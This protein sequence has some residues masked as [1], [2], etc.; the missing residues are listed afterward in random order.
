M[1]KLDLEIQK[2]KYDKHEEN[3]LI[4]IEEVK[5]L[6]NQ[7]KSKNKTNLKKSYSTSYILTQGNKLLNSERMRY[8]FSENQ[9]MSFMLNII[10]RE[11]KREEL[12]KKLK[13][14]E[15]MAYQRE[16]EIK[17]MREMEKLERDE[18][19]RNLA[20]KM[21]Q[22]EKNIK[23]EILKKAKKLEEEEKK[24]ILRNE[25]R[26]RAEEKEKEERLHEQKIKEEI[27]KKRIDNLYSLRLKRRNK[28]EKQLLMKEEIQK[29][30][31]EEIK[32]KRDKEIKERVKLTNARIQKA[33]NTIK[34]RNKQKDFKNKQYYEYKDEIIQKQLS[35]QR[36]QAKNIMKERL[37]HSAIKREEVEE[38]IKR[39]EDL[40]K[41]NR[42]KLMYEIEEK[43]KKIN[44]AKSQKLK[45]WEEQKKI[46]RNFEEKREKMM[47]KFMEIMGKRRNK[48]KEQIIS[49]LLNNKN[50][51]F[52]TINTTNLGST[53]MQKTKNN[54]NNS[55]NIFLTNLSMRNLNN[56]RYKI[57]SS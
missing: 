1:K 13:N 36:E 32:L 3:R 10:D 49:E 17:R 21:Q 6:R 16:E 12:G 11:Y 44:I 4:L 24:L 28:I 51:G 30:N 31:L 33:L 42:L 56:N 57:N 43:N 46:S 18:R 41:R 47:D 23:K 40:L 25:M 38:N 9:Q 37:I 2:Y 14:Q 29:K 20:L 52:K 27:F 50:I 5:K 48:S 15:K 26:K 22:R 35:I 19:D 53:I 54:N 55:G 39:K 8:K 7:M 34:I 45:I